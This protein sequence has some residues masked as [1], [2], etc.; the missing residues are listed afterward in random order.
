MQNYMNIPI[1]GNVLVFDDCD[2]VLMDDLALNILR[3]HLI[4]VR[5][6]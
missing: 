1:K 2:S 3:R 6:E 4:V 5:K